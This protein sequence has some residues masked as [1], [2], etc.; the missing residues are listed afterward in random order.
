MS[1]QTKPKSRLS[2]NIANMEQD[3][4]QGWLTVANANETG[5]PLL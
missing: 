4:L 3:R 1:V 2:M 5:E